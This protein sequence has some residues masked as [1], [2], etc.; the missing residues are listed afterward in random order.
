M[1]IS[2]T[3]KALKAAL[4]IVNKVVPQKSTMLSLCDV[5]FE[6]NGDNLVITGGNGET[7]IRES[8]KCEATGR[9]LLPTNLLDL[10]R[11]LP[12][13]DVVLETND[14]TAKLSWDS[15]TSSFPVFDPEDYPG[16]PDGGADVMT[17]KGKSLLDAV[18]NTVPHA[19]GNELRPAMTGVLIHAENGKVEFVAT[20][21][22]T[23]G[24]H[25]VTM[26]HGENFDILVPAQYIKHIAGL[27]KPDDEVK[28]AA[29]ETNVFFRVKDTVLI[30]RTIK[31]PF[32]KYRAIIPAKFEATLTV[33]KDNLL[34]AIKHTLV[35]V[36]KASGVIKLSLGMLE[37]MIET[38]DLQQG[39]KA[40]EVLANAVYDGQEMVVG[41]KGDRLVTCLGS[42]DGQNIKINL[43]AP[44]KPVLITSDTSEDMVL[45]MPVAV[46][47][48]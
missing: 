4:E 2:I 48:N 10:V 7:F 20:D 46:K 27:T 16:I 40:R 23:L 18:A 31:S 24:I 30:C 25:T 14:S 39:M 33:D 34:G 17:I 15:G 22:H 5:L 35:C 3:T 42:V 45:I 9:C 6:G 1:K 26:E 28:I 47:S 21:T 29:N 38:Q 19:D 8:V 43:I 36:D 11:M 32:P 12:E 41:F 44:N 37:T 13:G